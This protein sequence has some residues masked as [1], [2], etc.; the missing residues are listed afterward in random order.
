M[1][2]RSRRRLQRRRRR[3]PWTRSSRSSASRLAGDLARRPTGRLHG[4][5]DELGRQRLRNRDLARR[6][7]RRRGA[8]RQLTNAK[9]SSQS[10]AWSPDGSRLAFISDR[11]DKRQIYL[12][13]PLG[14]EA[15]ALTSVEDGVTSFAWSPDG[16]THRLHGD[17]SRSRRAIKDREKKYGEFE[18][19]DQ[20]YRM[21]HLFVVDVA[22]AR[23]AHADQRRVHRRQLRVVARR[24]EHRVRPSR[25]RRA[26]RAAAPPTSRSSRSPTRRS[27]TLVTQDGPGLAAG[28]VARRHAHRLRDGD[29]EPGV[30]LHQRVDRDRARERRHADRA[31]R[32]LR[33]GSVARRVETERHLFFSASQRTFSYL[34]R[35]DPATQGD[36]A[37][38]RPLTHWVGSSFTLSRDG[39]ADRVSRRRR[40]VDAGRVRRAARRSRHR[41]EADR[42]ERAD[43]AAGRPARSRSSRGRARTARRSK[44]CCTSRPTSIPSRK[45]PLLVV[46]HGGP[47]G[48]SRADAVHQHDLSDRRL[49]AARR[50][51]ARAE[52]PRQRRLRREVPLAQRAQPR[53][54]RRVGR[55]LGRR[56]ADREG[57]RRSRAGRHDGLEP[58]RLH[59]RVPRHARR[60]ALQGDLGRRRHLRLDDLLR[61]HRHPSRSRGST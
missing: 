5:R 32:R 61:Q 25:Q 27:A 8:P 16:R 20:D 52:L 58:G 53:R 55:A 10:P 46:I 31:H 13:N 6:R 23:H 9:K 15:E 60:R 40:E 19:V 22:H 30:L 51:R 33:R 39:V 45:Y 34:F 54:R 47:T 44:A 17:R 35:L 24:Q 42:H 50:P 48:V 12:I 26:R 11:T 57:A 38:S 14:G 29:G 2:R 28:L 49:G 43:R 18:V 7:E 56:L 4:A 1:L 36:R 37:R 59:L 21:T 41:D 3:R